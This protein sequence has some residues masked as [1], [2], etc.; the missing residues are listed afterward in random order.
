MDVLISRQIYV[1]L[2]FFSSHILSHREKF[3]QDDM[4][5]VIFTDHAEAI[6]SIMVLL[7]QEW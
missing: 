5:L 1:G 7:K 2:I 6:T 4:L 3:L